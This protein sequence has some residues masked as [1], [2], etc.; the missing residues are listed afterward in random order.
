MHKNLSV[1]S[2][3]HAPAGAR[4]PVAAFDAALINAQSVDEAEVA[5]A[6][7]AF[8]E[9]APSPG[10]PQLLN[11][12]RC[13][14]LT[15]LSSDDTP[16]RVKALCAKARQPL[17]RDKQAA[18]GREGITTAAVCVYHAFIGTAL[19]ALAGTA[20]PVAT[21]SAGF[22]HGLSPL[23]ARVLEVKE[24]VAAGAHEIDIV[25][26]RSKA[27]TG[28][29][30][31]IYDEVC[32]FREAC[33]EAHLKAIIG[34]GD[35]GTLTNVAKASLVCMMAGADFIKTSTGKETV[36]ATPEFALVMARTIAFWR[37]STGY[38]VG[39]KAAGGIS[40]AKE[41]PVYLAIMQSVLGDEWLQPNLFRIGASRL[42]GDI[43]ETLER[44]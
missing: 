5:R 13:I 28:D 2:N 16:E 10:A 40:K 21:V 26:D 24:S 42:L 38:K 37:K 41:V 34:T 17:S 25:I 30:Q 33:G 12:L 9:Q 1:F 35:L 22:P 3:D 27:L 20:V 39:F 15:T 4:N 32:L 18:L 8:A 19:E 7:A 6:V 36:N 14:D 23:R 43:V 29:W 44:S 31:G 11:A